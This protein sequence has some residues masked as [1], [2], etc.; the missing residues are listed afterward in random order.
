MIF[1]VFIAKFLLA[2]GHFLTWI[3][4]G[5]WNFAE[6]MLGNFWAKL[7]PALQN[8]ALNNDLPNTS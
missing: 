2:D 6:A 4:I 8:V 7:L 1:F 5:W 3:R